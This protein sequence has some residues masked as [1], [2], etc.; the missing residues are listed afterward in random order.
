MPACC[1]SPPCAASAKLDVLG[2]PVCPLPPCLAAHCLPR[3]HA[4]STAPR[5]LPQRWLGKRWGAAAP[6]PACGVAA[7]TAAAPH[8]EL[9]RR[10]RRRDDLSTLP[11]PPPPARTAPS[12]APGMNSDAAALERRLPALFGRGSRL[13]STCS[14]GSSREGTNLARRPGGSPLLAR[15]GAAA[16]PAAVL[17]SDSEEEL[18]RHHMPRWASPLAKPAEQQ[19]AAPPMQQHRPSPSHASPDHGLAWAAQAYCSSA[20]SGGS[21]WSSSE[22]STSCSSASGS[23]GAPGA[24]AQTPPWLRWAHREFGTGCSSADASPAAS[25]SLSRRASGPAGGASSPPVQLSGAPS[26]RRRQAQRSLCGELERAAAASP[27]RV[28]AA[29]TPSAAPAVALVPL[30]LAPDAA[31]QL[32][33]AAALQAGQPAGSPA[34][35]HDMGAAGWLIPA[36]AAA[37]S[38]QAAPQLAA[39]VPQGQGK[40]TALAGSAAAAAGCEAKPPA[41]GEERAPSLSLFLRPGAT[42]GPPGSAGIAGQ[43]APAPVHGPRLLRCLFCSRAPAVKP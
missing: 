42:Q 31:A 20:S 11:P 22:Y 43:P 29:G 17:G 10:K 24:G 5:D 12:S 32:G 16:T 8:T 39:S 41:A 19:A 13:F 9:R 36:V 28:A 4:T 34:P 15:P 25:P 27:A 3:P 6:K 30:L 1:P 14:S 7:V 40:A 21:S 35:L 26:S 37:L 18:A 2:S 23:G 33:L 38:Q